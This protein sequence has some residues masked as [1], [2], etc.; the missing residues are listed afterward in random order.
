MNNDIHYTLYLYSIRYTLYA[1]RYTL[2]D[3]RYT[4]YI[5]IPG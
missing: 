2:Y 5:G 4:L 1:I 3:I